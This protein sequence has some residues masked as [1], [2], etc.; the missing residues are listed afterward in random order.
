MVAKAVEFDTLSGRRSW[1][2]VGA[3]GIPIDELEAYLG[4]I[5]STGRA[6]NTVKSYAR[7]LSLFWRW[8]DAAKVDW[9]KLTFPQLTDFLHVYRRGVYP[10]ERADGRERSQSSTKAVAAAV[11][12]FID[13]QRAEGRGPS[14]LILTRASRYS[15]R[16]S[17]AFLAHI[18]Q[19]AP[20]TRNR[21][22]EGFKDAGRPPSTI[23]FESDF[24][25]LLTACDTFRDRLLLSA[26]YD[27]GMR[28]GQA[29][30]LRHGDLLIPRK[31]VLVERRDNN[32]NGA[33]SKT[34]DLLDLSMPRRFFDLYADYLL[35]EL[36]PRRLDSDYLFININ[37]EPL[38]IPCSYSNIYQQVV[39]I[40]ARAGIP[41]LTPHV[42]RHTHATYLAKM[43][44][45]SA[46]IAARLGQRH[47]ASADVYIHIAA[48]DLD[49]KLAETSHL[50]WNGSEERPDAE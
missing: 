29:L 36:M 6:T 21:L 3:D 2:V 41:S 22:V 13:F 39:S 7:H 8:L 46:E 16:T 10:L 45:T 19:R 49:Q 24:E 33:T 11:K 32:L 17:N 42:L 44:W 9:E 37:Q 12:E 15:V 47:A 26:M 27:G 30:G 38:G 43:G 23:D 14:Q 28:V 25:K 31:H 20:A 50:I 35:K 40:G 5:R 18:E 4:T 48:D 34:P 1:T